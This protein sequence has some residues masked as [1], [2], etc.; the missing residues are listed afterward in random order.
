MLDFVFN[1]WCKY[2]IHIVDILLV[3]FIVYRFILLI[4]GT[5]AVQVL[6]GVL[7]LV[8]VTFLVQKVLQLPVCSW[9]LSKFWL[10]GVIILVVVFQPELRTALAQLGSQRFSRLLVSEELKF[11]DE[12]IGAIK[13][14]SVKH[15]GMLI[16]LEQ[17]VGLRNFIDTGVIINGEVSREL[18]HSVFYP[19]SKLHDG[20]VI[21]REVRAVAAGCVLPLSNDPDISRILGTR[22]RAA[23]GISEISDAVVL[24]VSEETGTVS[25]ARNGRLE[26]GV[27]IDELRKRLKGLY[28]ARGEKG[29]L[30]RSNGIQG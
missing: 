3:S 30:R 20:A 29:L 14:A 12:I 4:K 11:V 6:L 10:A 18:L 22:H 24:V 1:I 9:I 5:R 2:L 26:Q 28:R 16:V 7:V 21:I 23:V 13:E 15:I 25:V 8:L 17:E 19:R 27:E